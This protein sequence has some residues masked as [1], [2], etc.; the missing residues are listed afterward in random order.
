MR[1]AFLDK[2]FRVPSPSDATKP[3]TMAM[4]EKYVG[5][6]M[7][8]IQAVIGLVLIFLFKQGGLNNQLLFS[9]FALLSVASTVVGV[10]IGSRY[11][12]MLI[13]VMAAFLSLVLNLPNID[14]PSG[15][16]AQQFSVYGYP[17]ALFAVIPSYIYMIWLLTRNN[18]VQREKMAAQRAEREARRAAD[19][20][21]AHGKVR[22][23]A[24]GRKTA[25]ASSRYTP[26]SAPSKTRQ[27]KIEARKARNSPVHEQKPAP[28]RRAS[29]F[30]GRRKPKDEK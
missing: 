7:V 11:L 1:S 30:G 20:A 23:S 25:T 27:R 2:L 29:I 22:Q 9:S 21:A 24:T 3:S 10:R 12:M 18:R 19:R 28:K 26:P 4:D 13:T 16:P 17:G 14:V 8:A 6:A 15:V 5:V